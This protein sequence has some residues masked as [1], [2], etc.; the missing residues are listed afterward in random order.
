[1][2]LVSVGG[3]L[4]KGYITKLV[5]E[6]VVLHDRAD[7]I[8]SVAAGK[9]IDPDHGEGL[10]ADNEQVGGAREADGSVSVWSGLE[11]GSDFLAVVI[12]D[13]A[14]TADCSRRPGNMGCGREELADSNYWKSFK[15]RDCW[16]LVSLLAK[17]DQ[18]CQ[19]GNRSD[20][21]AVNKHWHPETSC[22]RGDGFASLAVGRQHWKTVALVYR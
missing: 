4:P 6:G 7:V 16:A 18:D 19:G 17:K 15:Q 5:P 1:M 21:K 22:E 10:V 8:A 13:H 2:R 14:S 9:E 12:N 3:E 20:A 11:D